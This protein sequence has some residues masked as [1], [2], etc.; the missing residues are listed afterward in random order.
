MQAKVI[1][2]LAS[3]KKSKQKSFSSKTNCTTE[4]KNDFVLSFLKLRF[5]NIGEVM[6]F[7]VS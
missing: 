4:N 1:F 2:L 3:L 6:L 7:L 5:R